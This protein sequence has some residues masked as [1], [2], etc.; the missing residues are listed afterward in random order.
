MAKMQW[1]LGPADAEKYGVDGWQVI[2]AADWEQMPASEIDAFEREMGW[3]VMLAFEYA[4]AFRASGQRAVMWLALRKQGRDIAYADFDPATLSTQYLPVE[5][6]DASPPDGS[7][8]PSAP[9]EDPS[10]SGSKTT[11]RRS[12]SPTQD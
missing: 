11:P 1:K 12:P 2:D 5:E 6:G 10:A 3:S 9:S 7:T 8:E 4:R